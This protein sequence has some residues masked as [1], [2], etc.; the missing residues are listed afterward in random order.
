[1]ASVKKEFERH[2]ITKR[3]EGRWLLQRLYPDTDR[4]DWTM[5]A[6]VVC[7]EGGRLYVG[8]DIFPVIFAYCSDPGEARVRWMGAHSDI[9]HYV[10]EKAQ[11]GLSDNGALVKEY[12]PDVAKSDLDD[13]AR[14]FDEC[15]EVPPDH[16]MLVAIMDSKSYVD[17]GRDHLLRHLRD[18]ADENGVSDFMEDRYSF[19]MVISSR[20]YCAWGALS[21]LV[22]LLDQEKEHGRSGSGG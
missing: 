19:G 14:N 15:Y 21:R 20:V 13:L 9:T 3:S 6:E 17:D 12:N 18:A 7:L 11:I 22:Q 8:G 16:P 2:G 4:A 10:A 5:A 1:M